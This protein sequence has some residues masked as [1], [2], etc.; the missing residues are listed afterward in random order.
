M[1]VGVLGSLVDDFGTVR[2]G[3]E[4]TKLDFKT[5]GLGLRICGLAIYNKQ[6]GSAT[7]LV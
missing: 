1:G 3:A 6:L 5:E 7:Q 4:H 2:F